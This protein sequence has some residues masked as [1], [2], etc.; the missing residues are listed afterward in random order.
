MLNDP[1]MLN[2]PMDKEQMV[3][4]DFTNIV[5]SWTP[6]QINALN[7]SY[8][9][10]I[11]ELRDPNISGSYAFDFGLPVHKVTDI[12]STTLLY[13]QLMPT[14]VAG[15]RYAWRVKATSF[16]GLAANSVFK[17]DGYSE[18]RSFTLTKDCGVPSGILPLP[19][20]SNAIKLNWQGAPTH[21]KYHVQYR[22][23]GIAG[24]EWFDRY[25]VNNQ[26]IITDLEAGFTYEFR[27]GGTCEPE[28]YPAKP[29]YTYSDIVRYEIKQSKDK[30]KDFSCG[31]KADTEITNRDPM[32]N[33]VVN[34]SFYAGDLTVKILG[35]EGTGSSVYTGV[36]FYFL[37]YKYNR[38]F[39]NHIIQKYLIY[40]YGSKILIC[41]FALNTSKLYVSFK[42]SWF[43]INN[44]IN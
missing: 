23:E 15:K 8:T 18:V 42:V 9:F 28:V 26:T 25:V 17:N 27:V 20:G 13:N 36:V 39:N 30:D 5:F 43:F 22:K 24:A 29:N 41:S 32:T 12:R 44:T 1:P 31:L 4:G 11:K 35:L 7:V 3:Q 40:L 38:T 19:N 16:S 21:L 34:E 37:R 6:R 33:L 10:E 2:P 14:L